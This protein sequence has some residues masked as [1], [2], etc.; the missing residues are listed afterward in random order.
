MGETKQVEPKNFE[1]IYSGVEESLLPSRGMVV[2]LEEN[3]GELVAAY[4]LPHCHLVCDYILY[5]HY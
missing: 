2:L 3:N 4:L 5:E 1:C